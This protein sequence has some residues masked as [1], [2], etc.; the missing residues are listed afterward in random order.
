MWRTATCYKSAT[1]AALVFGSSL[2]LLTGAQAETLSLVPT[3]SNLTFSSTT[4]QIAGMPGI[5]RS[6]PTALSGAANV[7]GTFSFDGL[8]GPFSLNLAAGGVS[9]FDGTNFNFLAGAGTRL[10]I[11]PSGFLPDGSRSITDI[12]NLRL[13][14]ATSNTP[15]LAGT[16]T[17]VATGC[18]GVFAPGGIFPQT[19]TF[20]LALMGNGP[21][22]PADLLPGGTTGFFFPFTATTPSGLN[23]P[24]APPPEIPLPPAIYLFGSVLGG[25]F[26]LG[27]R[28][29][30]AV[31]SLGA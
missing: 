16:Y 8:T 29:R 6:G 2:A 24:E 31:S 4:Q 13:L 30:S 7:S 19:G 18:N 20:D 12:T 22:T 25:A 11:P 3:S 15:I 27:R 21:P 9:G 23:L 1:L 10:T 26:W 14:D 28:K 17:C 5:I